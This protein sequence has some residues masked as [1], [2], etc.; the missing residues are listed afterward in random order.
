MIFKP[1]CNTHDWLEIWEWVTLL[2]SSKPERNAAAVFAGYD[3]L[4]GTAGSARI[5]HEVRR[6]V[7]LKQ[8]AR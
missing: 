7:T 6:H 1:P 3:S 2:S 8:T 4:I 5:M